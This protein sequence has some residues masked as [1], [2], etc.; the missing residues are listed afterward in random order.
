MGFV[1]SRVSHMT[2]RSEIQQAAEKGD[3]SDELPQGNRTKK[4]ADKRISEIFPEFA[5]QFVKT[6][7]IKSM[8]STAPQIP[9]R[10]PPP[11]RRTPTHFCRNPAKIKGLGQK[12]PLRPTETKNLQPLPP[13]RIRGSLEGLAGRQHELTA[14]NHSDLQA[15]RRRS[16]NVWFA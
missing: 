15:A 3:V 9:Q 4:P 5:V 12:H 1:V 2:V 6:G 16:P 11:R 13:V 8:A 14:S 7:T 10:T